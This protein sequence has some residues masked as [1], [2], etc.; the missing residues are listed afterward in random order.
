MRNFVVEVEWRNWLAEPIEF[1]REWIAREYVLDWFLRKGLLPFLYSK[2]YLF[3]SDDS[4]VCSRIATGLFN[5]RKKSCLLSNWNFGVENTDY[6]PEDLDHY[7]KI[8]SPEVWEEFW[9]AWGLW[10]DVSPDAERGIDRRNDIQAYIWT[11]LDLRNSEQTAV[12]ETE[13][14]LGEEEDWPGSRSSRQKGYDQYVRE[15]NESNEWG[16]IRR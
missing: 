10:D 16:G 12:L 7:H 1:D 6:S 5:N 9:N 3:V 13:H 8:L 11:Q 2:K 4:V 14:G 15:A